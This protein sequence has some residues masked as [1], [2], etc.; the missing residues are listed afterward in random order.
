MTAWEGTQQFWFRHIQSRTTPYHEAVHWFARK[1]SSE[2]KAEYHRLVR[3]EWP[4]EE[5]F[6]V[7]LRL[8]MST[9]T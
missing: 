9:T 2:A 1:A 6:E 7:A 5:A 8:L 4:D 3:H